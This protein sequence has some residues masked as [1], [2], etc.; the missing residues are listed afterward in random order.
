MKSN[1]KN[2]SGLLHRFVETF[3]QLD[4]LEWHSDSPLPA[5]LTPL[6]PADSTTQRWQP[7][8]INTPVN[9][10]KD[11]RRD[12]RALPELF[13]QLV[14]SYRWLDVDLGVCRLL[15][16][17]PADDLTPLSREMFKDPV[18]NNT[19]LP[20]RLIRFAKAPF[21]CYDPICFDLSRA[22]EQ[23]CPIVRVNHETILSDISLGDVTTI[24]DSFRE[25]VVAVIN[26]V[27]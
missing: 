20:A 25:L 23:D 3:A 19:L 15:P 10:L 14:T 26:S 1:Q 22:A 8:Q 27:D 18:L 16:N 7:A 11:I 4:D 21:G 5:A 9:A 13:E 24:F 6:G 2:D 12:Q 17:Y